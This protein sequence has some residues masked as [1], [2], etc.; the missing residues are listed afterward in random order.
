MSHTPVN[1]I[2]WQVRPYRDGDIPAILALI[3]TREM[4]YGLGFLIDEGD[5]VVRLRGSGVDPSL[6]AIVVEG[7]HI[8]GV[9][10]G[11]LLGG[12]CFTQET[13]VERKQRSYIMHFWS[14]PAAIEHGIET[15]IMERLLKL[16]LQNEARPELL[17]VEDGRVYAGARKGLPGRTEAFERL[18]MTFS[19][20]FLLMERSLSNPIDAPTEIEGVTLRTYRRPEDNHG[21]CDAYNDSFS[22]HWDHYDE[23]YEGWDEGIAAPSRRPDLSWLAEIDGEQGKFGGFCI[24]V[25]HT[26]ANEQLGVKEGWIELLGTTRAYRGKGLGRS[27]LLHGLHSLRDDGFDTALLTVDSESPTGANLLY[28]RAGFKVRQSDLVYSIALDDIAV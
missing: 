26:E 11:A 22:D 21:A 4:A 2:D 23:S 1:S 27:L 20:Q 16:L 5:L 25:V 12:G 24:T 19:R 8:E 10:P 3:K 28:E 13:S 7:P 17:P 9:A 18:G 14:H 6:S 15:A